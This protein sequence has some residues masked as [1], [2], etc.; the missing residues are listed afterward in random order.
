MMIVFKHFLRKKI[1]KMKR[2]RNLALV[3]FLHYGKMKELFSFM[4][5]NHKDKLSSDLG[6][7]TKRVLVLKPVGEKE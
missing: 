2:Y 1:T 7:G 5:S 6:F 3:H 4:N